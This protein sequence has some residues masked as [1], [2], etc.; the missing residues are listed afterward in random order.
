MLKT[1][2]AAA[3]LLLAAMP[4]S[5]EVIARTAD[6]FTLR[7]S[8]VMETTPDD[9]LAGMTHVENWWDGAHSYSGDA[10]NISVDMTVGGCWCER[11]PNGTDFR[12][13]TVLA[14]EPDHLTFNAPFGPL[15]GKATRAD[16]TVTWPEPNRGWTVTWLMVIEG[17][18]LGAYADAVDGV[19]GAGFARFTRYLEYGEV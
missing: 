17:P 12:H 6:S 4:A 14:I 10:K 2:I 18:G 1:L 7:Y 9:L 13:A 16:F 15:N 19:M 11:L 3:A 5:A 8:V